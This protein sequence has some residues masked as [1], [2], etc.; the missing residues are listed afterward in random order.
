MSRRDIAGRVW[1]LVNHCRERDY[2]PRD[3]V[4]CMIFGAAELA[5]TQGAGKKV[6]V[7]A[8][9]ES[10]DAAVKAFNEKQAKGR[11]KQ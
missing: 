7:Q 3:V 8:C 9:G 5:R 6:F 11:A 1:D 4:Y 10:W 2:D